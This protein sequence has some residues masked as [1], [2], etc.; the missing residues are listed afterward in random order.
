MA[1]TKGE[2]AAFRRNQNLM[3]RTRYCVVCRRVRQPRS[4]PVC[5]HC[6]KDRRK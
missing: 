5:D 2:R 3:M 4:Y 1:Q 6:T